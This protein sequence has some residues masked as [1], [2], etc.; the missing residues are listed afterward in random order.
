MTRPARFGLLVAV[1]LAAGACR[2]K[3]AP[4]PAAQAAIA[5][6]P[7]PVIPESRFDVPLTY[8]ITKVLRDVERAVPT[9]FG[10]LDSVHQAGD[11]PSRHFA[12]VANRGPFT[13]FGVDSVFHLRATLTYRARGYYKLPIGPTVSA[14]CGTS[15]NHPP[16]AV[17]ELATPLSLTPDWHLAA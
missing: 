1:V 13:A 4:R 5:D 6:A 17:I 14:G 12:Y 11:D 10:S 3:P 8:D 15:T 7:P 16:R 9:Q 2:E